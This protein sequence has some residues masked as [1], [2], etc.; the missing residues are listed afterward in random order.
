MAAKPARDRR[1]APW[2]HERLVV[3]LCEVGC[4]NAVLVSR[5]VWN[6]SRCPSARRSSKRAADRTRQR[7]RPGERPTHCWLAQATSALRRCVVDGG[8]RLVPCHQC[9]PAY[10]P[11]PGTAQRRRAEALRLASELTRR[12]RA[13]P[14]REQRRQSRSR[15]Q[16]G[17]G[18]MVN[19][20]AHSLLG[21]E[22]R[23]SRIRRTSGKTQ[24]RAGAARG[25]T[26]CLRREEAGK[27]EGGTGLSGQSQREQRPVGQGAEGGALGPLERLGH[28]APLP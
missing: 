15:N 5:V 10:A 11:Q 16:N 28:S 26:P 20:A 13:G 2:R 1:P 4:R 8:P 24:G 25:R 9:V 17:D 22:E 21:L 27:R 14:G 7:K 3:A 23:G 18:E 6:G 12:T 19:G